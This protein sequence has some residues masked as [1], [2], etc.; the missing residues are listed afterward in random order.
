MGGKQKTSA[1][2]GKRFFCG[3]PDLLEAR[4]GGKMSPVLEVLSMKSS[5]LLENSP[6]NASSRVESLALVEPPSLALS[7]KQDRKPVIREFDLPVQRTPRIS[8]I[9]RPTWRDKA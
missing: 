5:N 3:Q 2:K 7:G 4:G 9:T 6:R 1:R 8:F